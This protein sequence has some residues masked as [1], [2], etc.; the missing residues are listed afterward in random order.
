M[1]RDTHKGIAE[2]LGARVAGSV[3]RHT[4]LVVYGP[5]AGSKLDK[6]NELCLPRM[7]EEAW[8]W[9]A[10]RFGY[11]K[12][13]HVSP[14][15]KFSQGGFAGLR[16]D[17]IPQII[18]NDYVISKDAAERLGAKGGLSDIDETVKDIMRSIAFNVDYRMIPPAT[19]KTLVRDVVMRLPHI[20]SP[21]V[22]IEPIAT[23]TATPTIPSVETIDEAIRA[24]VREWREIRAIQMENGETH[25]AMNAPPVAMIAKKVH[26]VIT[27]E[28]ALNELP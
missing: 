16:P 1:P 11:G 19:M 8:L 25:P 26:G 21:R 17:E 7:S 22:E 14:Y 4:T 3:H 12:P 27:E 20:T 9:L 6:A 18:N 10:A 15:G 5:S 28:I 2:S 23:P 13:Q 24:A